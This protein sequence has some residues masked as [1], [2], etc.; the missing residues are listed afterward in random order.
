MRH[1]QHPGMTT[2]PPR[3]LRA[4]LH[5]ILV[6]VLLVQAATA[7][8]L[9][10]GHARALAQPD[11]SGSSAVLAATAAEP[12][13]AA[14]P[15]HPAAPGSDAAPESEAGCC[16]LGASGFCS[17]A[18]AFGSVPLPVLDRTP[19]AP[20]AVSSP[21]APM[22]VFRSIALPVELRPPIA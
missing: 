16:P 8:A 10:T 9:G 2:L 3:R 18:C 12:N 21:L 4:C 15:C 19:A 11:A 22:T 6:L 7:L 20:W 13:T 5:L 1:C 14:L 17:W